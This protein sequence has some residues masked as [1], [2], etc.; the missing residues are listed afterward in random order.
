MDGSYGQALAPMG[1][2]KE[3]APEQPSSGGDEHPP[4]SHARAEGDGTTRVEETFPVLTSSSKFVELL[5]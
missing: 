3:K 2:S 1:C 4:L 5:A